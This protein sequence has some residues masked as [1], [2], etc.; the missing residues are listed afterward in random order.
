VARGATQGLV[1]EVYGQP[2]VL[3]RFAKTKLPRAPRGSI[4]VGAGD[5][6]A[7]ALVAFY[8]SKGDCVAL[9]PYTLA[10]YP[11]AAT[12]LEVFLIS[13]SGRTA[14]NIVAAR[15]VRGIARGT[16]VITAD[17][18]SRLA[19][20][21]D[22]VVS[23]PMTYSPRTSGMLSFSLSLLAVLRAAGSLGPCDF[24]RVLAISRR[25][26]LT[27]RPGKGTTY[28]LGNSLA[29]P[30]ALYAAAK[31]YELLGTKAHAE[32]LEEFSHMELFSLTKD[33]AVNAFS[34]FD[35]SHKA[36]KLARALRARGYESNVVP[37]VEGTDIERLFHSVFVVQLSMFDQAKKAGLSA[38]RFLADGGRLGVSDEM[39]Y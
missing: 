19:R 17:N 24:R 6:Y 34:C 23:L 33:D 37:S 16:T 3:K 27:T 30:V 1:E 29:Y 35:P 22:R 12:G 39:I 2:E 36:G 11:E 20:L 8:A 14:S 7:A 26:M 31:T 15:R 18:T 38:P 21:A 9:D 13:V 28:F 25:S 32:L 4:F 10:S 5:S